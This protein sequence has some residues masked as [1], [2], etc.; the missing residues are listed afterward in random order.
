MGR[1]EVYQ[2]FST[3]YE[4][5][6][7]PRKIGTKPISFEM[8]IGKKFVIFFS[9]NSLEDANSLFETTFTRHGYRSE[10]I[11]NYSIGQKYR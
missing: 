8:T 10:A 6:M 1:D 7:I 3:F 5:S 11:W 4:A 9:K 2:L